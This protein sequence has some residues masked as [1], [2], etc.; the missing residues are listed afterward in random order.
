MRIWTALPLGLDES[1]AV[2]LILSDQ[3]EFFCTTCEAQVWPEDWCRGV[4]RL[5]TGQDIALRICARCLDEPP[6]PRE[7]LV[8][9]LWLLHGGCAGGELFALRFEHDA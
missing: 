7:A 6:K 3:Q 4:L 9:A 1:V 8:R 5:P 2:E